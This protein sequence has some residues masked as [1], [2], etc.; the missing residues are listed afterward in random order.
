MDST[1]Y[2]ALSHQAAVNR[3]MEVVANN[4]ANMNTTAF[5]KEAVMF[6]EFQVE[7]ENA[8]SPVGN[9]VSFIQDVGVAN[10]FLPGNLLPT[11][12]ELDLA[13][14]GPGFIGVETADG[15]QRYTRNG[16]FTLSDDGT[17]MGVNG[18]TV[19]TEAGN[20][21]VIGPNDTNL[22]IGQ[23]GTIGS[24]DGPL[25]RIMI[26]EFETTE[27]LVKIGNGLYSSEDPTI[28]ADNTRAKQGM[29]ESSNVNAIEEMS[30]M[31]TIMRS[32]EK[33]A[34]LLKDFQDL[35][36]NTISTLGKVG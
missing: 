6:R 11:G 22:T 33:I 19:V 12:N 35:R 9:T 23:D 24:D 30:E 26:V 31:M 32:Y 14:T 16:H 5:Q 2:I 28:P 34:N 17:L 18:T 29:L 36:S 1:L 21:I 7:L 15:E 10:M 27:N 13:L 20:A 25:G 3:R 8:E 4:I